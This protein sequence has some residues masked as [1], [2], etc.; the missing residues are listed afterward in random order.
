MPKR[1]R[2]IGS[3]SKYTP[4]IIEE[5][6][7]H[8]VDGLTLRAACRAMDDKIAPSTVLKWCMDEN[9][10]DFYEQYARA[11]EIGYMQ[12]ADDLL[13]IADDSR[14]DTTQRYTKDGEAYDVADH[15]WINRSRLRVDT[16][17]WL[18]SKALPKIYGDKK[19]V[20]VSG[21]ATIQVVTGIRG[22]PGS[23]LTQGGEH[24]A[25]KTIEGE[26]V[27]IT[28]DMVGIGDLPDEEP[29]E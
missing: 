3:G 28:D 12:M 17:K 22:G 14:D 20:A 21:G 2:P 10:K 16:R 15:E 5:L 1:G 29:V 18:L 27:D 24:E 26:A 4:E 19:E 13:A 7:S 9:K 25:T 6:L 8:L 11:R 23:L